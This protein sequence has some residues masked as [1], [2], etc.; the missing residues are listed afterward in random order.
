MDTGGPEAARPFIE[1]AQPEHPSLIDAGHVLGE[2]LG[3]VNVPTSAWIDENGVLVRCGD[4]AATQG[5][6]LRD[7]E[8]SDAMPER[9]RAAL[10][11]AKKIDTGHERYLAAL[12]DWV[13][14]G[15]DSEYA[16]SPAEVVARSRPRPPEVALAAANFE[17]GE[18]LYRRSEHDAATREILRRFA[19]AA[20][21]D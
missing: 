10:G 15:A 7:I 2:L 14:K 12:R 11:E 5:G 18:H 6:K 16:L 3:F 19:A 9:V 1:K 21:P 20:D 17:L 8:I 4:T 13:K